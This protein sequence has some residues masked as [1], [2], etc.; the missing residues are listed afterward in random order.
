[1]RLGSYLAFLMSFYFLNLGHNY[2]CAN[3]GFV[4]DHLATSV[5]AVLVG[6]QG[7]CLLAL[8]GA[9]PLTD[10][11]WKQFRL[12]LWLF[13]PPPLLFLCIL[14]FPSPQ[15]KIDESYCFFLLSWCLRVF[16][17]ADDRLSHTCEHIDKQDSA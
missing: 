15:A 10:P 4:L 6:P 1:M 2:S 14:K 12:C 13:L 8:C 9:F 16:Y 17:S 11:N 7:Q 5:A 3:Q